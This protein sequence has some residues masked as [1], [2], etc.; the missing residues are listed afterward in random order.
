MVAEG[1]GAG[2]EVQHTGYS[3]QEGLPPPII[4]QNF[5]YPE[6]PWRILQTGLHP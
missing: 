3:I 5:Y 1:Q 2:L 4:I 6:L